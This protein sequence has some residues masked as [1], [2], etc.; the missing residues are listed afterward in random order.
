M[1]G[2]SERQYAARVGLSRGAIQ[3]AKATGRLVLH[4]MAASTR[5]PAMPCALKQPIRPRPAKRRSRSSNPSRRRRSPPWARRC[6]NR[7]WRPARRQRHHVPAGQDGQRSAEGAGAA[8]P[9]AKAERRV[10]RPGPRAVAGVPAGA[11]GARRLGQLARARGGADGGRSGCG[12]RRDAEG[13]GE[14]CPC[15]ARRSCRGQTRSPVMR[16]IAGLRRRGRDPA[17]LGSGPHA[18]S[19]PDRVGMGGPAPDAFGPRSAEPG[20]IARRA[21]PTW[22]RSWI[23]CRPAIRRSGSSS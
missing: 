22:A 2:L 1:E 19:G 23:G 7:G 6:A 8:H 20:G 21:R 13:S 18:G 4:A 16:T 11:A 5:W 10:D 3:K 14:T 15:P 12:A 9:A 17:R